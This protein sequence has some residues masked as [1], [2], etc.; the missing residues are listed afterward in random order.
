MDMNYFPAGAT[1]IA[2]RPRKIRLAC[3][4]AFGT[5]MLLTLSFSRAPA[6]RAQTANQNQTQ[7]PPQNPPQNPDDITAV[8]NRPTFST[9]AESVQRGVFEIEYGFE[10]ADAHQN[11]N[12]LLKFGLFKNLE[13]RFSQN[14]FE[15]DSG[16]AGL[17]DSAVGFKYRIASQ[18]KCTPTFSILYTA[19]LPT[20]KDQL[21]VGAT[22]HS[23]QILASKDFGK[24]HFDFNEGVQFVGR[25]GASGFD[26]NYFTALAYAHP[27][28]QKW[29]L[30]AEIAGFSNTNRE[31]PATLTL[32]GAA[33]YNVSSRLVL[34]G[35]AYFA[36]YG[37]LPRVTF[38]GGV[39]YSVTDLYHLLSAATSAKSTRP[40]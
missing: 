21:G 5:L 39:T 17:G 1:S 40:N 18:K 36:V 23:I 16:L 11:I 13:L 38:F 25:P 22:G 26:R 2:V 32:L 10:A 37:Q 9:T 3:S 12:G 24:N 7:N 6:A 14:P 28:T 27:L 33:T 19:T 15:R 8:P 4:V 29:A 20:A 34:D 31:T 35:G 30:T